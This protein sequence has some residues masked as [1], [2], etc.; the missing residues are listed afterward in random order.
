MQ[1]YSVIEIAKITG[2][3]SVA[4]RQHLSRGRKQLKKLLEN[5]EK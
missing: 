4:V 3:T 2:C 1:G 5:E